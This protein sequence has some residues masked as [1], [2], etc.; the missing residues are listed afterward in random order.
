M[1][2]SA[3]D[4]TMLSLLTI[5]SSSESDFLTDNR[6]DIITRFSDFYIYIQQ[7]TS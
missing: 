6:T 2:F 7:I 4:R 3:D 5:E 1:M